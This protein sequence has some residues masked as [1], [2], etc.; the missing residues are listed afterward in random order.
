MG[1]RTTAIR[2]AGI[3]SLTGASQLAQANVPGAIPITAVGGGAEPGQSGATT[4]TRQ[5][6][7]RSREEKFPHQFRECLWAVDLRRMPGIRNLHGSAVRYPGQEL[8]HVRRCAGS[9]ALAA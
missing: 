5:Q 4:T 1:V 7:T 9:I 2:K 3:A 6:G 8:C